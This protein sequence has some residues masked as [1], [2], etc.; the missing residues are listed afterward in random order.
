MKLKFLLT[1]AFVAVR[2]VAAATL[3]VPAGG[4][5]Q[6]T[7]NA[8]H[9]GDTVVIAAGA[10]FTGHYYLPANSGNQ[11]ITI[12]SS[13]MSSLPG[14]GTRVSST[15]ANLMPKLVTPDNN[16]VLAMT[17]GANY[18][19]LQGIEFTVTP[20]NY[21]NDLIQVG[22]G[23]ESTVAALPHDIDFDRDYIHGD[24]VAGTKRG[25]AL[26]GAN[27]TV[28]NCYMSAFTSN[29]QDT[30][31]I[32]GWNGTGPFNILNNYLEA[33]TEIVAFGGANTAIY[34]AI[35]SDI[36]IQKNTFFKP[37]AW[38]PTNPAYN[39]MHVWAKNHLEL[40]NAQRVTID[41][42]TFDNNWVGADQRGFVFVFNVRVELGAV[43]W[44]VVKDVTVTN[45]IIRHS[46]AGIQFVGEDGAWYMQGMAGNFV[47]KNN[48]WFDIADYWNANNSIGGSGRLFQIQNRIQGLTIDHNT[49]FETGWLMV[50]DGD[51]S[52]N[53]NVT[54]NIFQNAWG[55]A[56]NGQSG[57][58]GFT[59]NIN[60]GTMAKNAIIG[61]A[62]NGY[63]A[64]NYFPSNVN[65]VGFTDFANANYQLASSSSF[66]NAG[67][68]GKDLGQLSAAAAPKS[69]VPTGW[70]YLVSKNSGKCADVEGIS[71]T[72]GAAIHQWS[73]W[74]GENSKWQFVPVTG[75]YKLTNKN[76]NLQLDV[77]GGPSAAWDGALMI[78][79]GF[80]GGSNEIFNVN[81]TADGYVTISPLS[82]G[83]CL[84]VS[85]I[86]K[87]D[88]APIWQWSCVGGENQKWSLVPAQ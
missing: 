15:H 10:T 29:W 51:I 69:L 34:G 21:S 3:F 54:N 25:I 42:N 76:S 41:N 8:A 55:V 62:S 56:G 16:P 38:M 71:F 14:S 32:A 36:L 44:A 20:G 33:G 57:P 1:L 73:C 82:T 75:G 63:P 28:E 83:K 85:G 23:G 80:W 84:D 88:G 37:L 81:P 24:A 47:I 13:A 79:Y 87:D 11:W 39:G 30:Q 65:Q 50:F 72:P 68:D 5:L 58:A 53:V 2:M 67:T 31:A 40:K 43:P 77:Q 4:D 45:N 35:P 70:V 52:N 17:T 74:G 49:A 60:G 66:R 9:S 26:N 12:Q 6:G 64:G 22:N 86:S 48:V 18:Y 78:Q 46:A 7:L 61:G 19:R 59:A 27:V